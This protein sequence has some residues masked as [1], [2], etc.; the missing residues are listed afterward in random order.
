MKGVVFEP[1]EL[2]GEACSLQ[3][4]HLLSRCVVGYQND[5]YLFWKGGGEIQNFPADVNHTYSGLSDQL[6]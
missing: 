4:F 5:R 3:R 6:V 2:Q 1:L